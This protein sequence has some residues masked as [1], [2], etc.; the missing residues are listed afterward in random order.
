MDPVFYTKEW[1][2]SVL[3]FVERHLFANC[4]LYGFIEFVKWDRPTS[5]YSFKIVAGIEL[6]LDIYFTGALSFPF[7]IFFLVNNSKLE[8]CM[9]IN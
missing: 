3:D 8:L 4:D 2:L 7:Q 6:N 9:N 1:L 5:A